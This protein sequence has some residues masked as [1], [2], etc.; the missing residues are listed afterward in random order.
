MRVLSWPMADLF[1][2]FSSGTG[3]HVLYLGPHGFMETEQSSSLTIA[4]MWDTPL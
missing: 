3:T 2:V 4:S 1:L